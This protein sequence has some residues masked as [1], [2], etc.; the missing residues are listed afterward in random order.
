MYLIF[1]Y[2]PLN[3][4]NIGTTIQVLY[5]RLEDVVSVFTCVVTNLLMHNIV[6]KNPF[7]SFIYN[8]RVNW[9]IIKSKGKNI[10]GYIGFF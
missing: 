3:S 4:I 5:N 8:I 2:K 9:F 10:M 6:Q 1:F 7:D